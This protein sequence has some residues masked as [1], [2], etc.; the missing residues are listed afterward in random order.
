MVGWS[1][2]QPIGNPDR[3]SAV[4][5]KLYLRFFPTQASKLFYGNVYAVDNLLLK[6]LLHNLHYE[7]TLIILIN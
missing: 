6:R 2:G 4:G 3:C 1:P 5:T 7:N